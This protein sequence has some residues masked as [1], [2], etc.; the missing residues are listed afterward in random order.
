MFCSN[1]LWQESF[2]VRCY[3]CYLL[4]S[5][6]FESLLESAGM[7][8]LLDQN[9]TIFVPSNDAV[10]DFR[11]DLEEVATSVNF[12]QNNDVSG[13]DSADQVI[14]NIDDGFSRKKRDVSEKKI[15][16]I[17]RG[18]LVPGYVSTRLLYLL[19]SKYLRHS[20]FFAIN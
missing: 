11:H 19:Q 12:V 2:I 7:M 16:Q 18:H 5:H 6:K 13:D 14:Y 4:S 1:L 9:L 15:R 8:E 17:L 10:E 3:I 20:A